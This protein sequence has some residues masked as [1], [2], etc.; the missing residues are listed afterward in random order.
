MLSRSFLPPA[1]M[2]PATLE[3]WIT[4]D[5]TGG[6]DIT[7]PGSVTWDGG[8]PTPDTTAGVTVRYILESVDGGSSWIGN[9]VGGSGSTSPLSGDF[10][11]WLEA[12]SARRALPVAAE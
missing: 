4:Q 8:T 7:W 9:L 1:E 5:G 2:P 11:K 3:F 10:A 6:W 12:E